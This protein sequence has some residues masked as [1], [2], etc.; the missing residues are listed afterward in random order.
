MTKETKIPTNEGRLIIVY[1]KG[2]IT[3]SPHLPLR[4]SKLNKGQQEALIHFCQ[5]MR[6]PSPPKTASLH[7]EAVRVLE[8][9]AG[10]IYKSFFLID[11]GDK[12]EIH[13]FSE[14][15]L[16]KYQVDCVIIGPYGVILIEA[17]PK[18]RPPGRTA[19]PQ[20]KKYESIYKEKF[21][22]IP[23]FFLKASYR[24]RNIILSPLANF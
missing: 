20:L 13:A 11:D 10:D 12:S 7:K 19:L 14:V 8:K 5:E 1:P 22:Q 24:N 4:T 21:P 3:I 6:R 16:E 18:N 9:V 23:F 15:K 2:E 17:K